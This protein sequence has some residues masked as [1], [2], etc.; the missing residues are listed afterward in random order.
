VCLWSFPQHF[1][2]IFFGIISNHRRG[3]CRSRRSPSLRGR[4]S[5]AR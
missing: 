2:E 1:R 3:R 5:V 4:R